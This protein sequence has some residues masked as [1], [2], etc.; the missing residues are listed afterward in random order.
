M[1]K[2]NKTARTADHKIYRVPAGTKFR[3]IPSE[4]KTD[5]C[6]GRS[7]GLKRQSRDYFTCKL[8]QTKII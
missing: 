8:L 4:S 5:L 7:S 3:R 6:G 1:E 2:R